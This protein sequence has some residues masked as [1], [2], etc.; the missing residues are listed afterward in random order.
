MRDDEPVIGFVDRTALDAAGEVVRAGG[1]WE[2]DKH[3]Y[4]APPELPQDRAAP[5]L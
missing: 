5:P 3:L 1:W 4:I 2:T